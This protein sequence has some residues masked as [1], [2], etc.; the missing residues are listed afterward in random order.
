MINKNKKTGI[1][2]FIWS[3]EMKKYLL[4]LMCSF[5]LWSTCVL[6]AYTLHV[7]KEWNESNLNMKQSQITGIET[8][9]TGKDWILNTIAFINNYLWLS[10]GII[11]FI[12]VIWNGFIMVT[13]PW[14]EDA[15]KALNS[16]TG[17]LIGIGIC[18]L[19]YS[20][21]NVVINLFS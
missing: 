18:L 6:G 8:S 14:T 20:I 5:L 11:C 17:S 4:I 13:K 12:F 16:L 21:V 19:A 7:P 3:Y 15:K 9:K 1:S 10:I 2:H